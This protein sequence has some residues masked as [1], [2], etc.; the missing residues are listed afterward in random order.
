MNAQAVLDSLHR[1][2]VLAA[3]VIP[4]N[5][6]NLAWVGVYRLDPSRP[7][8]AEFLRREGVAMLPSVD[9][10]YHIRR[11]EVERRFIEEDLSVAEPEMVA[12]ESLLAIGDD[13]LQAKLARFGIGV[14]QLDLPH[15]SNYPI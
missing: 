1:G 15:K 12:K 5:A 6:A 4:R 8:T 14:E 11:F 13:D 2:A 7:T 10:A 9:H 3:S